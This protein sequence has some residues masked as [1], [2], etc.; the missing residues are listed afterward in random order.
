MARSVTREKI[1]EQIESQHH[2]GA[3]TVWLNA[4]HKPKADAYFCDFEIET[5]KDL[6]SIL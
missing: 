2:A 1:H 5:L 6:Q 3:K 4:L